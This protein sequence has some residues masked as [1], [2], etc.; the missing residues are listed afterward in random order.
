MVPQVAIRPSKLSRAD[1]FRRQIRKSPTLEVIMVWKWRGLARRCSVAATTAAVCFAACFVA[2]AASAQADYPNKPV[3]IIVPSTPGGGTDTVAR[4][5]ATELSMTMGQQFYIDNKAGAASLIGGAAAASSAPDGY[6]LLVAPSTM[7]S[8]HVAH[9]KMPFHPAKDLTP[10]TMIVSIPD[11]LLVNPSVPAKNLQELLALARKNPGKLSY[12][13]PGFAST[14]NMAMELLKSRTGV[15]IQNVPYKGV[16]PA[17]VDV[18]GGRVEVMMVNLA[19]AKSYIDAGKLRP[20]AVSTLKRVAILPDVPTIA[21]QG[22]SGYDVYQWFGLLAPA[23]TPKAIVDKL[24]AQAKKALQAS[25]V[26]KWA[27]AEGA[28]P[29]GNTPAEFHAAIVQEIARWSDVASAAHIK[30]R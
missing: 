23:G 20:I 4:L 27:A 28:D 16:A 2:S 3:R 7:T 11:V 9:A 14:T 13:S 30:S 6:T 24:Y 10:V 15:D 19:S 17:L 25:A 18:I 29:V 26:V 22:V 1:R 8:L 21:E 5:L 12:A